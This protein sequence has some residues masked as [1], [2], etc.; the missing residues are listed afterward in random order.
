MLQHIGS[1]PYI[2]RLAR[3][4][5][6]VIVIRRLRIVKLDA[7]TLPAQGVRRKIISTRDRQIGTITCSKISHQRKIID[8]SK[9]Y[10]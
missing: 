1:Q 8:E 3:K 2:N 10:C 7:V 9:L 4:R 6:T 5:T